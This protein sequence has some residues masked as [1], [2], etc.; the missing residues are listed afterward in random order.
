MQLLTTKEAVVVTKFSLLAP[1][2][3]YEEQFGEY[4]F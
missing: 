2:E 3:I 1:Q 4:A